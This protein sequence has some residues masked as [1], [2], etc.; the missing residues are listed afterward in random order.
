MIVIAGTK[1]PLFVQ[2]RNRLITA[3]RLETR[4]RSNPWR[5]ISQP[6]IREQAHVAIRDTLSQ[7]EVPTAGPE[8]RRTLLLTVMKHHQHLQNLIDVLRQVKYRHL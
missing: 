8:E 1:V 5:H 2:N 3:L 6:T 7:W 4:P